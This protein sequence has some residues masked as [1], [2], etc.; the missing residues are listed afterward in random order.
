MSRDSMVDGACLPVTEWC[1][2]YLPC[3]LFTVPNSGLLFFHARRSASRHS[4]ELGLPNIGRQTTPK[5]WVF[6][7]YGVYSPGNDFGLIPTVKW[8]LGIP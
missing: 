7:L 1:H 4:S 8:K 2:R 3:Y 5:I 6:F